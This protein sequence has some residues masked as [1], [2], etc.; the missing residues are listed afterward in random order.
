VYLLYGIRVLGVAAGHARAAARRRCVRWPARCAA[1]KAARARIGIGWSYFCGC[2]VFTAPLVLWPLA[3]LVS[4]R[5]LVLVMLFLAEFGCGFGVMMLDISIG[6]IF[7]R[8]IPDTLRSRVT[9]AFQSVNYG[10]RPIG[11]LLGGVLAS[12][13]GLRLALWV[14][15]AGGGF[16]VS[17]AAAVTAARYRLS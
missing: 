3:G 7:A 14:A 2:L 15:I 9:G 16:R 5:A 11:A 10:T 6:V 12:A 17:A 13:F 8:V 1:D 4:D